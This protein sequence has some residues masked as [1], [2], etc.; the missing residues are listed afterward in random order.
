MNLQGYRVALIGAGLAAGPWLAALE[1]L[2]V[3][4]VTVATRDPAR[5]ARVAA[6][7]P[8]AVRRWPPEE[9]LAAPDL[10]ACLNL[11]PPSAHLAGVR[12]AAERHLPI[13]VEKP[14][15]IT[16]DR[17]VAAVRVA[18]QAG[19]PLAV[20]LQYRY[21]EGARALA[22]LIRA[23]RLGQ[24]RGA[25]LEVPWWRS[26]DYYRE[27]GRGTYA[28]DGGGV[29]ITQAIHALD[30]LIWFLGVPQWALAA[31]RRAAFHDIEAEDLAMA[32]LGGADGTLSNVFATTGAHSAEETKIRVLGSEATA[33]LVDNRLTLHRNG[34]AS[35]VAGER[36][37]AGPIAATGEPATA[38]PGSTGAGG[39]GPM[40]FPSRWHQ[41]LIEE[42]L[43]AF[44]AG[45]PPPVGGREAVTVQAVID[46]IERS[47]ATGERACVR[48][49]LQGR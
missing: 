46:A 23:G 39:A 38:A 36:A 12:L 42:T 2:G 24:L 44:A 20:C 32:V 4:V 10:D 49:P 18:E 22:G 33:V 31:V 26:A 17:A 6:R 19:I 41:A 48:D 25:T 9:A 43:T 11:A 1:H 3:D 29:L 13:L 5:F 15:E 30:L 14:L 47:A 34:E 28:R 16:L 45:T 7:F 21:R 27:P 35:V 40:D 37:T 8:R